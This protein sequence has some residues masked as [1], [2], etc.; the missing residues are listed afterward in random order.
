MGV[1][2]APPRHHHLRK[3]LDD[4]LRA[5]DQAEPA[6]R[7]AL[8]AALQQIRSDFPDITALLEAG[9]IDDAIRIF[10]QVAPSTVLTEAMRDALLGAATSVARVEA[11]QIGISFNQVNARAVRWAERE[12][13]RQITG[14][15][16]ALHRTLNSVI[17][18]ALEAG[19]SPAAVA[20]EIR[21]LIGLTT[22]QARSV[23]SLFLQSIKDGVTEDLAARIAERNSA[24]LI[25][26]RAETIART[27]T[28]RA[29]N[30]GQQLVWDEA[31][32]SNLLPDTAEKVWLATG[33]DRT[34]P[35]CAVL[36]GKVIGVRDD[37]AVTERATSFTRDGATFRVGDTAALKHPTTTRTP[38]AH[39]RCRCSI[40][41]K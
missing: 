20:R 4:I 39:P 1:D 2:T 36:D 10:H 13:A 19:A 17:T 30:M 16:A 18:D 32:D 9:R 12:A 3:N 8:L 22:N 41:L 40:V 15:S 29:A 34:C 25:R 5:A 31:I 28:I 23:E 7:K 21:S 27:E 35:I 24:R 14:L 38:P 26:F 33:D 37:F 11:V 6:T